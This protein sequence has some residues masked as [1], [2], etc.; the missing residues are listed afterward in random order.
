[1][2]LVLLAGYLKTVQFASMWLTWHDDDV[3]FSLCHQKQSFWHLPWISFSRG[4]TPKVVIILPSGHLQPGS[5]YFHTVTP[6]LCSLIALLERL[7]TDDG[8][9]CHKFPISKIRA[10][11]FITLTRIE[12][13]HLLFC[14]GI[15]NS[16]PEIIIGLFIFGWLQLQ[17]QN[18]MFIKLSWN[19]L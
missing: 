2:Q 11:D 16:S 8:R 4:A 5:A 12:N 9:N 18:W 1:M 13:I 10:H 7:K 3:S 15:I 19:L 17:P 6:P 14:Q